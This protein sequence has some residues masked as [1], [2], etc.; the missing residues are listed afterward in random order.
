MLMFSPPAPPVS[1]AMLSPP[2]S[3]SSAILS[4]PPTPPV[5]FI[6]SQVMLSPVGSSV[7]T[8][9]SLEDIPQF[10]V[11]LAVLENFTK[12]DLDGQKNDAQWIFMGLK[13]EIISD[14]SFLVILVQF[15]IFWSMFTY[16]RCTQYVVRLVVCPRLSPCLTK[17]LLTLR[18]CTDNFV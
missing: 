17:T 18:T 15:S 12:R 7:N 3:V 11:T 9:V 16:I 8:T 6:A 14:L 4:P 5:I 13:I 1:S 10:G 2:P